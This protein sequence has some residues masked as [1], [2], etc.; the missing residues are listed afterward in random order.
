MLVPL[1]MSCVQGVRPEALDKVEIPEIRDI[2]QRCIMTKKDE[3]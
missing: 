3:R 2:I 1:V